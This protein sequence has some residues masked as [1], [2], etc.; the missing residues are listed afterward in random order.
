MF[1]FGSSHVILETVGRGFRSRCFDGVGV[2]GLAG[3][4]VRLP[5]IKSVLNSSAFE[6]L[7]SPGAEREKDG[8]KRAA[9]SREGINHL[10]RNLRKGFAEDE[11]IFLQFAQRLGEH[12]L[13]GFGNAPAKFAETQGARLQVIKYER[14]PPPAHN[15][16]GMGHRTIF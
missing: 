10:G 4:L 9:I 1:G 11:S 8:I 7:F 14:L 5:S 15:S 13:G 12:F 16:N 6:V 2:D 3:E